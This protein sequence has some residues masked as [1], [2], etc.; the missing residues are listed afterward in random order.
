MAYE[1]GRIAQQL[2]NCTCM[3]V[4]RQEWRV[5]QKFFQY[6]EV[7]REISF[8]QFMLEHT[9][10]DL[11]ICNPS[12]SD[13]SLG[14]EVRARKL[15]YIQGFNTFQILDCKFDRYVSVSNFV[16]TFIKTA[17]GIAAEVIP[18]FVEV[19]TDEVLPWGVRPKNSTI[20][21]LKGEGNLQNLLLRRF[22][23]ECSRL[24]YL[25]G[26]NIEQQFYRLNAG[27]L[28]Q[29]E[30]LKKIGIYR[31]FVSLSTCEGFGLVPLEAMA[32]GATVVAFDGFG[33]RDYFERDGNS[34]VRAFPDIDGLARDFVSIIKDDTFAQRLASRGK[35]TASSY[36]YA[37][38]KADWERVLAE[39]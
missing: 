23:D 20:L 10:N 9:S 1:I 11:F 35:E 26:P 19:N 31:Y 3:V 22:Y 30:L 4:H 2:Y 29:S 28:C 38:F 25:E 33:G 21:Y 5:E 6:N 13:G 36:S 18:P 16:H 32:L 8:A 24:L 17:Y 12:F 34:L 15:M 39:L 27:T 7:Y 14:F 37:R